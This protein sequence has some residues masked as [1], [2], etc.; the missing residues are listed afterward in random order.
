M[1][2]PKA[3]EGSLLAIIMQILLYITNLCD[4]NK[5]SDLNKSIGV[6]ILFLL[7][8]ASFPLLHKKE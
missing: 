4:E 5:S 3:Y 1:K 6:L 7:P 8:L 2:P